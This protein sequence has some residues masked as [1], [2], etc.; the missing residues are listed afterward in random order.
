MK[1]LLTL[2]LI[3]SAL[4]LSGCFLPTVKTFKSNSNGWRP[5]EFVPSKGVLLIERVSWPR[6]QQRKIEKFMKKKYEYKYEFVDSKDLSDNTGKYADKNIYRFAMTYSYDLHTNNFMEP[7][8]SPSSISM[9]D[10][11]FIDRL[12]GKEHAP[13]GIG[14]SWASVTFKKMIEEVLKN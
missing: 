5:T 1:K 6:N 10:F 4:L 7:G 14:S 9:F 11:R 3:I 8:K 13:S 2:T 12:K